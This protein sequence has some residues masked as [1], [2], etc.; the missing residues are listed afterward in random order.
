M[1]CDFSKER[2]ISYFYNEGT[3]EDLKITEE[4]LATCQSCAAI[5]SE[6]GGTTALLRKWS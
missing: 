2:L 1:K 4:H 6:L 3:K 5:V